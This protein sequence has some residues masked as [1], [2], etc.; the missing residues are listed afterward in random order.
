MVEIDEMIC[1]DSSGDW[2]QTSAFRIILEWGHAL[3]DRLQCGSSDESVH[4]A[5]RVGFA[6]SLTCQYSVKL[7]AKILDISWKI[8]LLGSQMMIPKITRDDSRYTVCSFVRNVFGGLLKS[9]TVVM[10]S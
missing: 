2:R 10:N 4:L 1:I 9:Q 5:T 7:P 6:G 3:M 8:S